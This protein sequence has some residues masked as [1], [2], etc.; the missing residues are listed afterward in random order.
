MN[1]TITH[2]TKRI[3]SKSKTTYTYKMHKL[4]FPGLIVGVAFYCLSMLPSLLPR[5]WLFQALVSGISLAI[6]YLLGYILASVWRWLELKQP[7]DKIFEALWRIAYII[8][9]VVMVT[10][11]FIGSISQ[12][13]VHELAGA[14]VPENTYWLRLLIISTVVA[15]GLILCG[16]FVNNIYNRLNKRYSKYIP[17][18][19]AQF[20][21]ITTTSILLIWFFTGAFMNF[22]TSVSNRIFVGRNAITSEGSIQPANDER[23]GSPNSYIKWDSLGREGRAFTGRGP[24]KDDLQTYHSSPAKSPIRIYAGLDSAPTVTDRAELVI[25]EIHRTKAFDRKILVIATPTGSGWLEREATDS[26]EYINNGDTAIVSQQYSY[27]PSWI[28]YLTDGPKSQ[29]SGRALYDAVFSEWS[30]LPVDKRPKLI[31]YGLSLGSLGGQSAFTGPNGLINSVDGALFVGTP[32]SSALW[33]NITEHRDVGS[34]EWQPIFNHGKSIRFASSPQDVKQLTKQ[35]WTGSRI[36][37]L[38]HAS[39]PITWYSPDLL[40][41]KPDWLREPRGSGVSQDVKW[42]PIV[43]YI[44]LG[45]DQFFGAN[46]PLGHGHNYGNTMVSSWE[47][48]TSPTDWDTTRSNKL[49]ELILSYSK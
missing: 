7:N 4:S 21:A 20:F 2:H 17:K 23:S 32:N 6:G 33:S 11:I 22:F 13:E 10:Y 37:Y 28:S 36:L 25:K 42:Y 27:L 49:Q 9:P 44:Q 39:D 46:V 5:P 38:Q 43:T 26:V 16:R 19:P 34:P 18:R 15:F 31:A 35:E 8:V 12:R 45:I 48:I 3:I 40:F 29:E 1:K 24:T 41:N 30:K 47:A 14:P